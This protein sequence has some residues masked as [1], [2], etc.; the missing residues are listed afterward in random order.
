MKLFSIFNK[1]KNRFTCTCCGEVYDEMPLC[2]GG[3][4]PDFYFT[5]PPDEREFRIE[6]AESLCGIDK[7]HFFHRGR[8]VIPIIDHPE[9]LIFNVWTSISE[10]NLSTRTTQWNYPER[11]PN[12]PYCGW[13]QTI[14]PTYGDIINIKT[15]A[16]EEGVGTL[17]SIWI[18]E[19]DHPLAVDQR[20]G[21]TL[22]EATEKVTAIL[23]DFH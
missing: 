19:E 16:Q 20:N 10:E 11:I 6:K 8:I 22:K 13:L 17:P 21:I 3:D 4:Y 1:K 18:T 23:R 9:P 5:V 7:E 2:F 14:V 15:N 12:E